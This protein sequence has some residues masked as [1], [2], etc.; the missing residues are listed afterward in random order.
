MDQ[1]KLEILIASILQR[2]ESD[3]EE[4]RMRVEHRR[5]AL[6]ALQ[7]PQE[8]PRDLALLNLMNLRR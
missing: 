1:S 3:V 8:A 7:S 5:N 2:I 6:V 4:A